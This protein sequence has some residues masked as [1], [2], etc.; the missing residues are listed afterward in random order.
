M[1]DWLVSRDG[2]VGVLAVNR[3][4][5]LN[6]VT[7]AMYDELPPI[8]AGFE[9]DPAVRVVVVRGA[10]NRAFVA[11]A[12]I[13]EFED[14]LGSP[15][16]AMAYDSRVEAGTALIEG[17]SKPT[18][19][20]IHGFALG[21][22]VLLAAACSLRIASDQARFSLPVGRYGIMPSPPDLHRLVRLVGYGAALEMGLTART[23][24]A[25]E[26]LALG[27]VN[28]VVP[29][30]HLE[31]TAMATARQIAELAPLTLQALRDM[32]RRL[33]GSAQTP[34][35]GS[36]AAWYQRL[37]TSEDF[38]EGARAF[39]EKRPPQFGGR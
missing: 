31:A 23:Y 22:G 26:A 33:A 19:A 10:G 24:A 32:A 9:A 7:V 14:E 28:R 25:H 18:I 3:P 37:Y 12:D 34:A 15:E 35:V 16:K 4:Q 17:L 8:L 2:P 5:A 27:L 6:A 20:M 29:A 39:R 1:G 36:E 11:G 13:A 21:T 38:R 30:E